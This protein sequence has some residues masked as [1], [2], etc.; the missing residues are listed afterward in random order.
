MNIAFIPA[1]CGS[2]SIPH[3]N[4]KII[5]GKPLIYWSLLALSNSKIIDQIYVATDC[6][7]IRDIVLNLSFKRVQIFNRK[8]ENATDSASTESVMME[9]INSQNFSDDDLLLLVQVTTPF[10]LSK[11]FDNALNRLKN[12]KNNSKNKNDLQLCRK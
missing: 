9:F 7:Q 8:K 5:C 11:D 3:K 12:N 1:R 10:T 6:K 4:V 2:K